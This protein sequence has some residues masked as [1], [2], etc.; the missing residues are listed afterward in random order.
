MKAILPHQFFVY[1]RQ[2]SLQSIIEE[3]AKISFDVFANTDKEFYS[4]AGERKYSVSI[5]NAALRSKVL[6]VQTW[7]IDL[8]YNVV[9]INDFGDKRITNNEALHLIHLHNDYQDE[10]D[11]KRIKSH[12]DAIFNL[13]GFFGEQKRFEEYEFIR[14][15]SR[16]EYILETISKLEHP[17]NTSDIDYCKEFEE[18]TGF[19]PKVFSTILF[20]I[21]G[22][23]ATRNP[24]IYVDALECEFKNPYMNTNNILNI[25]HSYSCTIEELKSSQL[26]R[27][28]LYTKPFIRFEDKY[29]SVNPYLILCLFTNSNYWIMR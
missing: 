20:S 24:I 16:E 26:G 25:I 13:Y 15:Y 3:I 4:F 21:Y 8:L 27:Q 11:G 17:K 12:K 6:I 5:N 2:F 14:E 29:I 9:S 23:V 1:A 22:Y 10:C 19:P 28:L 7:L 18:I